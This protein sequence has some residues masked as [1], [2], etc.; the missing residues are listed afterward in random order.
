MIFCVSF[1]FN[2]KCG[3][4]FCGVL[5]LLLAVFFIFKVQESPA[6]FA[7]GNNFEKNMSICACMYVCTYKYVSVEVR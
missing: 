4:L 3:V 5:F 6:A 1:A 7:T 2:Y